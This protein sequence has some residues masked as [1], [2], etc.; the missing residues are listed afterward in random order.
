MRPFVANSVRKL[1][2]SFADRNGTLVRVLVVVDHLRGDHRPES[3]DIDVRVERL[4]VLIAST[5]AELDERTVSLQTLAAAE[6]IDL[7]SADGHHDELLTRIAT[8]NEAHR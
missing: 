3:P 8:I 6:G 5:I 7:V 2:R 4:L 1:E